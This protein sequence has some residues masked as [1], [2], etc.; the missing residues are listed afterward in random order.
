MLRQLHTRILNF[1]VRKNFIL[2]CHLVLLR[3]GLCTNGLVLDSTVIVNN[4]G[5]ISLLPLVRC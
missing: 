4:L 5:T 1:K 3:E 2:V